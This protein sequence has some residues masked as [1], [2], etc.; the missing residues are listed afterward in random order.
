MS[1]HEYCTTTIAAISGGIIPQVT[2]PTLHAPTS[3][4]SCGQIVRIISH[5]KLGQFI[6]V[7]DW[8]LH[9]FL[10]FERTE[11]LVVLRDTPIIYFHTRIQTPRGQNFV[12]PAGLEP[13]ITVPKTVVIS[14]SPQAQYIM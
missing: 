9:Y 14:I 3:K 12:R 11:I 6:H 8:C 4:V 1:C 5:L 7:C 10:S 2:A 13:A